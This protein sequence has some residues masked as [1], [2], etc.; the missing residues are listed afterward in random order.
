VRQAG[1]LGERGSTTSRGRPPGEVHL[2]ERI[3]E[4]YDQRPDIT[5]RDHVVLKVGPVSHKVAYHL[6]IVDRRTRA[7]HHNTVHLDTRRRRS[8]G[9]ELSDRHSVRAKRSQ[10]AA[11]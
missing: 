1:R 3:R 8:D 10:E 6:G 7:F 4:E 11:W 9:W 2:I 5:F